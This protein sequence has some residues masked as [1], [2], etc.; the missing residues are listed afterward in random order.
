MP[1]SNKRGK[2]NTIY[3]GVDVWAI[4]RYF[5]L[6]AASISEY[7][8]YLKRYFIFY[9]RNSFLHELATVSF[10]TSGRN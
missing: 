1:E 7:S 8:I 6:Q 3:A 2:A 9:N 4:H 10:T 5:V